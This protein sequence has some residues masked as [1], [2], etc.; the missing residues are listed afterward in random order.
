MGGKT[1]RSIQVSEG[2][3]IN[4][5]ALGNLF[6]AIIINNRTGGWRKLTK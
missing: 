4:K 5:R 1:A 2:E 6:K 3:K